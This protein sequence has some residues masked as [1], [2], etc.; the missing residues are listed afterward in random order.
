MKSRKDELKAR[1]LELKKAEVGG[2]DEILDELENMKL[3]EV[4]LSIL[5]GLIT[6]AE[7]DTDRLL[8]LD[9]AVA[10]IDKTLKNQ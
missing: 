3:T 8:A 1:L 6:K 10:N 7:V 5:N 4:N 2:I 9:K